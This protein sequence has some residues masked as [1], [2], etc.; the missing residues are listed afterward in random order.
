MGITCFPIHSAIGGDPPTAGTLSGTPAAIPDWLG[1]TPAASAMTAPTAPPN[2]GTPAG[3]TTLPTASAAPAT[4]TAGPPTTEPPKATSDPAPLILPTS[5]LPPIPAHLVTAIKD[6]KYIDLG[7]LLPEGLAEAFD[8]AQDGKEDKRKRKKFPINTPMEWGL[9][10]AT[11]AAVVAHFHP[12]RAPPLLGYMS[13][14]FRLAREVRSTAWARYDQAFRQA[15]ALNPATRWDCR[16]PDIWLAAL[17]E[18]CSPVGSSPPPAKKAEPAQHPIPRSEICHKWNRGECT[19][20]NCRLKHICLA[21]HV[22]SHMGK[23]CYLVH[24]RR[25]PPP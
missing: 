22:P 8:R 25:P 7:D 4:A 6:G 11:Y 24:P 21:C 19:M 5:G 1:T 20:R 3:D 14:I 13:I 2:T 10:F 23:D 12:S 18:P 17:V 16:Q 15:A 9:A